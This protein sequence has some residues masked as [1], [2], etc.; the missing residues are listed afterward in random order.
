MSP[1]EVF[2]GEAPDKTNIDEVIVMYNEYC[3]YLQ[4]VF[5]RINIDRDVDRALWVYGHCKKKA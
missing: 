4:E 3:Y 2:V 1:S 5:G